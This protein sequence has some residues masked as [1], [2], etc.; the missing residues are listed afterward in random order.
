ML[1]YYEVFMVS[2]AAQKWEIKA[3]KAGD[4][5]NDPMRIAS[6]QKC[7][8]GLYLQCDTCVQ[9]SLCAVWSPS[10]QFFKAAFDCVS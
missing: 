1:D 2:L 9:V 10:T 7:E 6:L 8:D 5:R 3:V 4:E